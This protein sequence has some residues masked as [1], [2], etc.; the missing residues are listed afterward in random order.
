VV[1]PDYYLRLST[2]LIGVRVGFGAQMND[3]PK[4]G[5]TNFNHAFLLLRHER[6]GCDRRANL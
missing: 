5:S 4:W 3:S 6:L 1:G 2:P